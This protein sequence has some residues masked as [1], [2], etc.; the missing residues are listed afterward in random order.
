MKEKRL[1]SEM[2][3]RRN[4]R[5]TD[6]EGVAGKSKP[7]GRIEKNDGQAGAK[8]DIRDKKDSE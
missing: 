6:G 7:R 3:G 2:V 4:G 5:R 1:P 8:S